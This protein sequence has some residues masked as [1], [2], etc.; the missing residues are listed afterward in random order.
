M[1]IK[2]TKIKKDLPK[3]LYAGRV[4]KG[5]I[6]V[7]HTVCEDAVGIVGARNIGDPL[8]NRRSAEVLVD[9][10][11]TD[12]GKPAIYISALETPSSEEYKEMKE[13]CALHNW[14]MP[15]YDKRAY[16]RVR[17]WVKAHAAEC[18]MADAIKK[19]AT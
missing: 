16:A 9:V 10:R 4:I 17:A 5:A 3:G 8:V 7:N 12:K 13:L 6:F 19:A 14:Q 18:A 2:L 15:A 11:T 1:E